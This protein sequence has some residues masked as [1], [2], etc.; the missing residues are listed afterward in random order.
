MELARTLVAEDPKR[1]VQVIRNWL[2][3]EA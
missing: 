1:A 2:T 3:V